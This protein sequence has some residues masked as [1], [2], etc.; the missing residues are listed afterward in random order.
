MEKL[1]ETLSGKL[2]EGVYEVVVPPVLEFYKQFIA[3]YE[4][5]EI[6]DEADVNAAE[7]DYPVLNQA[8]MSISYDLLKMLQKYLP[9]LPMEYHSALLNKGLNE[10]KR[11][12]SQANK[13]T[14]YASVASSIKAFV[15]LPGGDSMAEQLAAGIRKV[16]SRRPTYLDEL[17]KKGL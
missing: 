9:Q 5:F 8:L 12:A 11:M 1:A 17:A 7:K 4:D 13:R 16:F 10:L 14:E 6:V 2:A 3:H 15:K